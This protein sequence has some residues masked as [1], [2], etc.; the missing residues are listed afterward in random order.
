MV[1]PSLWLSDRYRGKSYTSSSHHTSFLR[2]PTETK[3]LKLLIIPHYLSQFPLV[4][5]LQDTASVER[6]SGAQT[7][8]DSENLPLSHFKR[9]DRNI[10]QRLFCFRHWNSS[11]WSFRWQRWQR[12]SSA[13]LRLRERC[14]G[15][16]WW[17][18][19]RLCVYQMTPPVELVKLISF[20][21]MFT[22]G[23]LKPITM[24]LR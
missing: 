23:V 18:L 22:A 14:S 6:I 12:T 8:D 3:V 4:Y 20:V 15:Y 9:G 19:T 11:A 16:R 17:Y 5:S 13:R 24:T 2:F 7:S 21:P 1:L 10:S